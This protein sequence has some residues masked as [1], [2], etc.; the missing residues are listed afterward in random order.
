MTRRSTGPAEYVVS[1]SARL[2]RRVR[3]ASLKRCLRGI[4]TWNKSKRPASRSAA[5][6]CLTVRAN[7]GHKRGQKLLM[8]PSRFIPPPGQSKGPQR[9]RRRRDA[10]NLFRFCADRLTDC[11]AERP[12]KGRIFNHV[13][14]RKGAAQ[15]RASIE[16]PQGAA[17][18]NRR[19]GVGEGPRRARYHRRRPARG[20]GGKAREGQSAPPKA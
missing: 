7:R 13:F 8:A 16:E 5:R 12:G 15:P 1:S 17:A 4:N 9:P 10:G 2:W 20:V 14:A 18:S 3:L 19:D 6:L 11:A